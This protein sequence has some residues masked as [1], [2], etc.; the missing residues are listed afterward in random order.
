M[1]Y[2]HITIEERC[3][4]EYNLRNGVSPSKIAKIL[5]RNRS[6]ISRELKRNRKEGDEYQPVKAQERY[7]EKRKNSV[8]KPNNH[9]PL[10]D[11]IVSKL[12][13]RWS[14]EQIEN[15]L[16]IDK[17]DDARMR[18]SFATIYNWIDAKI[19]NF[20]VKNL[21]RKGKS[22][23]HNKEEKRG[24]FVID[25]PIENR[26]F[27]PGDRSEIGNWEI[28][29]VAGKVGGA[30]L[31]TLVERKSRLLIAVPVGNK[32]KETINQSMANIIS[33]VPNELMKTIT[34]D[35]GKE[36]AG[37]REWGVPVYFA[38]RY[39]PWER[40]SNENTNGLLREFFPKGMDLSGIDRNEILE[41]VNMI[42]SRPRKCLGYKT[43]GEIFREYL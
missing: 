29:T 3:C 14:P 35:R 25:N 6:S 39:S 11:Y 32:K 4:I 28:D 30:S 9:Q 8:R 24:R 36:F 23:E 5:G 38:N 13:I 31:V 40:G 18:V 21:R 19:I 37:Y 2:K 15:R 10:K 16:K 1:S 20:S 17:P 12:E 22:K 43:A 33:H 34:S 41:A 7:K 26:P 27:P 42:N